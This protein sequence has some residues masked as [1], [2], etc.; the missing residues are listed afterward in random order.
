M[1][2]PLPP[3][4]LHGSAVSVS[5]KVQGSESV[6]HEEDST[7][8]YTFNDDVAARD[9]HV[10]LFMVPCDKPEEQAPYYLIVNGNR[11]EGNPVPWHEGTWHWVRVSPTRVPSTPGYSPLLPPW[12]WGDK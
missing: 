6:S 1:Q 11:V 12:S 5:R 9:A 10:V 2:S 8:H 4:T 7:S 3:V